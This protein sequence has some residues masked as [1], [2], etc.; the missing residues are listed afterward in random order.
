MK[1]PEF[2]AALDALK[3]KE[4]TPPPAPPTAVTTQALEAVGVH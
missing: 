3:A 2:V 4:W 1:E